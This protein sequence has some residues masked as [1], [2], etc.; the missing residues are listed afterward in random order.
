M[1]GGVLTRQ[2]VFVSVLVFVLLPL[3]LLAAVE[4]LALLLLQGLNGR[5]E[6]S[7]FS[8]PLPADGRR[9]FPGVAT[10]LEFFPEALLDL[11]GG[12][13]QLTQ[14]P[15]PTFDFCRIDARSVEGLRRRGHNRCAASAEPEQPRVHE[16]V[17][18]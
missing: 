7:D 1:E 2:N 17:P 15:D 3:A 4:Q 6:G 11:V 8:G 16:V 12:L 10:H 9:V 13:R 14:L 18:V 5:R